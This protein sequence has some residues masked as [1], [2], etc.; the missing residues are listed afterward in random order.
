MLT[1]CLYRLLQRSQ[2][3]NLNS[4]EKGMYLQKCDIGAGCHEGA[5]TARSLVAGF[6][7]STKELM[8][9]SQPPEDWLTI[10]DSRLSHTRKAAHHVCIVHVVLVAYRQRV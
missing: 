4:F 3:A 6:G 10:M 8:G 5:L 7:G 9:L 1:L 2:C